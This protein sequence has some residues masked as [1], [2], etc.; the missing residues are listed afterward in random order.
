MHA[1]LNA[2]MHLLC[3]HACILECMHE[4]DMYACILECMHAFVMC[5]CMH[6]FL[7]VTYN[8]ELIILFKIVG[9]E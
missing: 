1:F 4:F 2:Y 7:Q 8:M 9:F 5:A 3:M 6:A